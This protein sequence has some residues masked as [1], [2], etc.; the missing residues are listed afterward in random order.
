[1]DV[2]QPVDANFEQRVRESFARQ[3]VMR[4]IG[5]QLGRLE[6]GRVDI[7]LPFR[8]DL[9]QQHGFFHAG[10]TST[11]ADSAGGYAAY[12]LFPADSSVLT[13]EFK[14]NLIAPAHGEKLIATGQVK[15][16]A[17]R[18]PSASSRSWSFRAARARL[19]R[20]A[21]RLS[22][23]SRAAKTCPSR[24]DRPLRCVVRRLRNRTEEGPVLASNPARGKPPARRWGRNLESTCCRQLR[25]GL[26]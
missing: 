13:V 11:I 10:I 5:A 4:L 22:C 16:P 24:A 9:S 25:R 26:P 12:T 15:S 6:P 3:G 17:A 23:V 2:F 1:M 19:A 8:D 18:S 20:S 14:I 7:E 21:C